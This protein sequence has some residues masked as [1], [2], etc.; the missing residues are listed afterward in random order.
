L[1]GEANKLNEDH[2]KT[3][4]NWNDRFEV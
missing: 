1:E 3:L 2:M 4:E